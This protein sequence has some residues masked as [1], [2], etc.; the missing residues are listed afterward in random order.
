MDGGRIELR[1]AQCHPHAA[2]GAAALGMNIGDPVRVSGRAVPEDLAVD[3]G[4]TPAS[5]FQFLEDDDR[6]PFAQH[7]PVPQSIERS[8]SLCRL[9]VAC[10][11]GRQQ[12]EARHAERMDHAMGAAGQHRVGVAPADDLRRLAHG[13]AAGGTGRQAVEVR[14]LGIEHRGDDARWK[15]RFLFHFHHRIQR[16]EPTL[17]ELRKVQFGALD[18]SHDHPRKRREI[19]VALTRS[20]V[21]AES[22]RIESAVEKARIPHRLHGCAGGEAGMAASLQP[23]RRIRSKLGHRPVANFGG[24]TR[25]HLRGVKER[26]VADARLAFL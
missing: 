26:N 10:R 5:V 9:V 13:L 17:D 23:R 20:E 19:L 21:N 1:V 3:S 7:K 14:P 12:V 15:M 8:R 18:A 16:F 6:R 25:R 22:R 24:D 4:A 11:Q 2:D